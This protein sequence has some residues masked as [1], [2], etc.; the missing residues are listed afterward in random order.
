M[1][2]IV[3]NPFYCSCADSIVLNNWNIFNGQNKT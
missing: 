1:N 2:D 3:E